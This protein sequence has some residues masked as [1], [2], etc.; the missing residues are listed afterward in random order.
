MTHAGGPPA[1][2]PERR[3]AARI[4]MPPDGGAVAVVG[5]RL[6]NVNRYGMLIESPVPMAR[7]TV[8]C[9]R[10]LVAGQPADLEARVAVCTPQPGLRCYGVGLEFADLS[11]SDRERLERA[12]AAHPGD[13]P[14]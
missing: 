8:M 9:L 6:L 7:E 1:R 3:R 4:P 10:V 12:L 5:A 11:D 14:D 13:L 2:R